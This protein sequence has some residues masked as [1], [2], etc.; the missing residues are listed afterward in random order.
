[1]IT[2]RESK[3]IK[4]EGGV[5][6]ELMDLDI[7]SASELPTADFI[8]GKLLYQGSIAHDISTG[9]FYA[10]DSEG[11]WFNQ[12]GSGEYEPE[13]EEEDEEEDEPDT[14]NIEQLSPADI[15]G[16]GLHSDV[17]SFAAEPTEVIIFT[18]HGKNDVADNN[19]GEIIE[20]VE[21][22]VEPAEE[23]DNEGAGETAEEIPGD[24]VIG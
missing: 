10:I 20:Q 11:T 23:H 19:V 13:D 5:S 18:N 14:M 9:N 21:V 22:P 7:G 2:V 17:S 16:D 3:F 4:F 24:E 8:E 6:V 1:M 15:P 12:D